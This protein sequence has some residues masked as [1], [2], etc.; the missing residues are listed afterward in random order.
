MFRNSLT[1]I[2]RKSFKWVKGKKRHSFTREELEILFSLP[3]TTDKFGSRNLVIMVVMYASG[4]RAQG[5]CDLTVKDV[6]HDNG[7]NAVLT[8]FGKG[9][10][11]R[12][13]RI[14]ADAT[15]LLNKH[16][17]YRKIGDQP[18]RHV[19]FQ[20]K[21]A[22]KCQLQVLKKSLQNMKEWPRRPIRINL[23]QDAT[24][25]MLCGIQQSLILLKPGL[26][27]MWLKIFLV[28]LQYNQR[29]FM[30]KYRNKS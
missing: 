21:E 27:F 28:T 22:N 18:D 30:W 8:L 17:A 6:A 7:G 9:D 16:I 10:K 19:F 24:R 15:K 14:T 4:A 3:D 29:R 2:Y 20:S 12:R 25:P 26:R 5:V 11:P 13:M 1:K 23:G